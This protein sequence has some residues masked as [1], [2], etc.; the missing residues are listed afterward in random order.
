MNG[1]V[2]IVDFLYCWCCVVWWI[3]KWEYCV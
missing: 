2:D 1:G 3:H